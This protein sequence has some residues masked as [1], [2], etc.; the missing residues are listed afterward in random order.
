MECDSPQALTDFIYPGI[1]SI[2][3]PPPDYFLHR[4]I[5]APRNAD[6]SEINDT[7][8]A[9]MSGDSRTY[10]SADKVI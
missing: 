6:V 4:M 2:P 7:V 9:A 1:S 3:P 5:L 10:Y 8:L